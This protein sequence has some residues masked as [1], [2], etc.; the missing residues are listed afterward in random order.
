MHVCIPFHVY[1]TFFCVM[2]LVDA[3]SSCNRACDGFLMRGSVWQVKCS[4]RFYFSWLALP[5]STLFLLT[6]VSIRLISPRQTVKD[7]GGTYRALPA[8]ISCLP[9]PL[10]HQITAKNKFYFVEL[11]WSNWRKKTILQNCK[12]FPR[13]AMMQLLKTT[14]PPLLF[15]MAALSRKNWWKFQ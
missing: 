12:I 9:P 4:Y 11:P 10:H 7:R 13:A 1:E 14:L 5:V 6:S 2:C 8:P 15:S 3:S